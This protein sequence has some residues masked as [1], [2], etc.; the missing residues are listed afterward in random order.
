[1]KK[2][3]SYVSEAMENDVL[4]SK[5]EDWCKANGIKKFKINKDNEIDV[6]GT[7][8]LTKFNFKTLPYKFGTIKGNFFLNESD[9]LHSLVNCPTTVG[10]MFSCDRNKNLDSLEGCPE[11][12]HGDFWCMGCKVKFKEEDVKKLCD[13]RG[14][15][16]DSF[17]S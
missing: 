12:V 3:N 6:D 2:L 11:K 16:R 8:T 15:I 1:M 17:T 9:K 14:V 10:G 7:V 4:K 13:V 5:M